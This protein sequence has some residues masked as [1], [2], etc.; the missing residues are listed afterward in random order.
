MRWTLSCC[1]LVA[2]VGSIEQG[3]FDTTKCTLQRTPNDDMCILVWNALSELVLFY[4]FYQLPIYE[5][6][7]DI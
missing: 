1:Y 6:H 4:Q 7:N 5:N 3:V 2:K